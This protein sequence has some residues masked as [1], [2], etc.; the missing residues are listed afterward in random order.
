MNLQ[1]SIIT[2]NYNDKQG[3]ENT[4]N[5]VLG[6]TA[7]AFEFIIVD[8]NS[9]DGSKE[10]LQ[11]EN[12]DF[13]HVISEPDNGIYQAMNKG[14]RLAKGDYLLFLNS[15][16]C[17]ADIHV[18]ETLKHQIEGN[19]DIYYG[20][21]IFDDHIQKKKVEFPE[22]LTFNFFFTNNISHQASFIKR[23][24]FDEIFFY[25]ENFKIVSDWE[26]FVCAICK[27]NVTYK[28]LDLVTTI[29]DGLGISSKPENNELDKQERKISMA[30]FFP[31]FIDDYHQISQLKQKRVQ[32]F[33]SIK[34][35]PLAWKILKFFMK[36][37]LL[38]IPKKG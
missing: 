9:T 23:T 33:F 21:I 7:N 2:V 16:D 14:I 1:L 34:E 37:I 19:Y 6:Q 32:Q 29:Y 28:H 24:L 26:F 30:K 10:L 13:T 4:I 35:R 15:G 3:L 11:S 12:Y 17:L 31:A 5:S 8:G 20:D 25:N 22:T 18:I 27:Y 38:F 36:I